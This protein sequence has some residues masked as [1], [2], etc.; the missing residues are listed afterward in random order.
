MNNP[1]SNNVANST[2]TSENRV[3]E[4]IKWCIDRVIERAVDVWLLFHRWLNDLI[5]VVDGRS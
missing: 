1:A 3:D 2:A 4:L 5:Y